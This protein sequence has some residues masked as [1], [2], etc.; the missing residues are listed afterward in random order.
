M[1][2]GATSSNSTSTYVNTSAN[3]SANTATASSSNTAL[4]QMRSDALAQMPQLKRDESIADSK[5]KAAQLNA[6]D[7]KKA[8]EDGK[9]ALDAAIALVNQN[10]ATLIK[11]KGNNQ[12]NMRQNIVDLA[13]KAFDDSKLELQ[14]LKD[15]QPALDKAY[16]DAKSVMALANQEAASAKAAVDA[17]QLIINA[18][19]PNNGTSNNTSTDTTTKEVVNQAIST[20]ETTGSQKTRDPNWWSTANIRTILIEV[21]STASDLG[22]QKLLALAQELDNNNQQLK[23]LGQ[24]T[25]NLQKIQAAFGSD[26]KG[27]KAVR[28]GANLNLQGRSNPITDDVAAIYSEAKKLFD[29][30]TYIPQTLKAKNDNNPAKP[31]SRETE[32]MNNYLSMVKDGLQSGVIKKSE[33]SK[34][35]EMNVNKYQLTALGTSIK[36]RQGELSQVNNKLQTNEQQYNNTVQTLTNLLSQFLLNFKNI[37]TTIIGNTR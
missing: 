30:P 17:T 33:M 5:A 19:G 36:A 8:M 25:A 11:E 37:D 29:D 26:D 32:F 35:A 3:T 6:D 13:Q 18:T 24:A 22:N 34:Y 14:K 20:F 31:G 16:A 12:A 21:L 7:A 10:N 4:D 15:A 9:K 23:G 28:D 27:D 2:I 1:A